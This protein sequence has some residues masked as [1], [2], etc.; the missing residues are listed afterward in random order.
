MTRLEAEIT[1][2]K[3]TFGAILKMPNDKIAQSIWSE[4]IGMEA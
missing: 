1:Q 4:S 2:C 3:I